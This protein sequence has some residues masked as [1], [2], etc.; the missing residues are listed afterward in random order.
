MRRGD[1]WHTPMFLGLSKL[2]IITIITLIASVT[3]TDAQQKS[4]TNAYIKMRQPKDG[5]EI[6]FE[7][8][9]RKYIRKLLSVPEPEGLTEKDRQEYLREKNILKNVQQ[10]GWVIDMDEEGFLTS[11]QFNDLYRP[12]DELISLKTN[13][14]KLLISGVTKKDKIKELIFLIRDTENEGLLFVN[15]LLKKPV[16]L[17]E[18]IENHE[19]VLK[20]ISVNS[21]AQENDNALIKINYNKSETEST[22]H[23]SFNISM[24]NASINYN[25]SETGSTTAG[26]DNTVPFK[27]EV[28]QVDGKYGVFRIP[29]PWNRKYLLEPTSEVEPVIYGSNPG[30]TYFVTIGN[31]GYRILYDKFG[32][33]VAHGYEMV[34]VY[35]LESEKEVAAFIIRDDFGYSLYECPETY[36]LI[37]QG[38]IQTSDFV[39]RPHIERS[40]VYCQSIVLT[41]DGRLECVKAD[42]SIEFIQ[43]R[44]QTPD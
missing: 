36:S 10:V 22:K 34:P 23:N 11:S 4:F 25:K 38:S 39:M 27:L 35:V 21:D 41:E 26:Y 7:K 37:Q 14:I 8:L 15:F 40:M 42:G 44:K 19:D 24:V 18:Y 9:G 30:N 29:E 20:L 43:I 6:I 13:D 1:C 17:H 33:T 32:F 28:V 12:Y 31:N 2:V 5:E 3:T 16:L